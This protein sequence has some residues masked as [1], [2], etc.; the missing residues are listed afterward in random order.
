LLD[1]ILVLS[2]FGPAVAYMTVR[3]INEVL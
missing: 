1:F 2:V 3:L